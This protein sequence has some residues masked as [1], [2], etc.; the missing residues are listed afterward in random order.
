MTTKKLTAP[1]TI[2]LPPVRPNI[3]VHVAYQRRLDYLIER[4]R[5]GV[6]SAII[7]QWFRKPPRLAQDA[8]PAADLQSVI[9]QLSREWDARFDAFANREARQFSVEA[10][11]SAERTFLHQLHDIGFAVKFK[12]TPAS[13]DLLTATVKTQVDLIRSIP[14]ETLTQIQGHV[15]RSAQ[16]GRDAHS[17]AVA[18]DEQFGVTKRRA[19]TIAEIRRTRR[20]RPL[21]GRGR[22]NWVSRRRDGCTRL[23]DGIRVLSMLLFPARYMISKKARILRASGHGLDTK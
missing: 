18:L 7:A 11:G 16:V 12:M 21:P 2:I 13:Q 10:M 1:R 3:G 4:M 20:R 8:S 14:Q 6:I 17:L 19:A 5:A 23:E 22:R 15:M 9:D